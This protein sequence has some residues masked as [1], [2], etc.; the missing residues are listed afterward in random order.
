MEMVWK[1]CNRYNNVIYKI[2]LD[3]KVKVVLRICKKK[4][5]NWFLE[6]GVVLRLMYV[7]S[8]YEEVREEW[9]EDYS[10]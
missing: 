2:G 1:S 10:F 3:N 7:N 4:I 6:M 9:E 5:E 8:K